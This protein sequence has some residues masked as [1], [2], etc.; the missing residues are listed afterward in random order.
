MKTEVNQI[1][2]QAK[3]GKNKG[4]TKSKMKSR[5]NQVR[6]ELLDLKYV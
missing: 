5:M 1:K 6:L 4:K 2:P 3:A